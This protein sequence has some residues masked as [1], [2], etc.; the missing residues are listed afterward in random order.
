MR[1]IFRKDLQGYPESLTSAVDDLVRLDR[2][3][4]LVAWSYYL[5][6]SIGP[7]KRAPVKP[8]LRTHRRA[9]I[10]IKSVCI[11]ARTEFERAF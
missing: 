3:A 5:C 6:D 4:A 10:S 1:Q 2:A 8:S 7:R 9:G 11:L